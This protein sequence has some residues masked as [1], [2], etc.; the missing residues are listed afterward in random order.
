MFCDPFSFS[1]ESWPDPAK[2]AVIEQGMLFSAPGCPATAHRRDRRS[3][4]RL[5]CRA[6]GGRRRHFR[7]RLRPHGTGRFQSAQGRRTR[8]TRRRNPQSCR[9]L[10]HR[11]RLDERNFAHQHSSGL[12]HGHDPRR[13]RHACAHARQRRK[14][15]RAPAHRRHA[16][17]SRRSTSV[18]SAFR[19]PNRKPWWTATPRC[20]PFP[21]RPCWRRP[22]ATSS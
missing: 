19:C 21:R 5:P 13:G 15:A 7:R 14:R 12:A 16:D 2:K 17:H 22:S 11:T 6:R 20:L 10:G 18:S 9:G 1:G 3:R 4:K 8:P